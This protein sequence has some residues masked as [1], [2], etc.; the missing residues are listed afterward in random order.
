MSNKKIAA[1]TAVI[2]FF[3]V[4]SLT[5]I[6]NKQENIIEVYKVEL[7]QKYIVTKTLSPAK[8]KYE[9]LAE[10]DKNEVDC[11]ARN[12]YFEAG[13]E[14]HNGII[15]VGM[16]TMNRTVSQKFPKTVCEVV[17]QK[18]G[19]IYQFSWVPIRKNSTNIDHQVYN[20]VLQKAMLVYFHHSSMEDVTKGALFFHADYINPKWKREK[21]AHIGRHIFYR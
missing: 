16:V 20:R 11:L 2:T 17:Y 15:A 8:I 18:T 9:H 4:M 1:I 6:F 7:E 21:V 13:H 5:F 3:I 10:K 12:M 14:P 19:K